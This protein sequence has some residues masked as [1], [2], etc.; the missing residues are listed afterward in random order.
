MSKKLNIIKQNMQGANK[1]INNP[2]EFYVD[3]FNN[4]IRKNT[5]DIIK[6]D[7]FSNKFDESNKGTPN[8]L[9]EIKGKKCK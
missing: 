4:I 2:E 5:Q 9:K 3:L 8:L 6:K 7:K 1:N